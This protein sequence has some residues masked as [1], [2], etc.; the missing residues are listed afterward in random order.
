[1]VLLK[2][3]VSLDLFSHPVRNCCNPFSGA[4]FPSPSQTQQYISIT[5]NACKMHIPMLQPSNSNSINLR[6]FLESSFLTKTAVDSN[7]GGPVIA[8][9]EISHNSSLVDLFESESHSF[10]LC[11]F[12]L[13]FLVA[14]ERL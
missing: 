7:F 3:L 13:A 5:F 12:L 2:I 1:M 9:L 4:T 8:H 11:T 6:L 10:I 14:L